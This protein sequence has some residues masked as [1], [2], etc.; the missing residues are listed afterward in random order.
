MAAANM[1]ALFLTPPFGFAVFYLNSNA[2]L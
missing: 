1:R 2:P